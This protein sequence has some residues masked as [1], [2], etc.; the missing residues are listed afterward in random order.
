MASKMT[1]EMLADE[2]EKPLVGN[3]IVIEVAARLLNLGEIGEAVGREETREKS[4]Q[5]GNSAKIREALE[6]ISKCDISKE[7][8]CY[9]LYRVCEA[10]LA[11]PPRNCDMFE[12]TK[13]AYSRFR[14]FCSGHFCVDCRYRKCKESSICFGAWLLDDWLDNARE[15]VNRK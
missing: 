4:S 14:K 13:K 9:T 8:D 10:A 12:N 5:V 7:E 2:L 3:R 6:T 11:A 15:L 1:N